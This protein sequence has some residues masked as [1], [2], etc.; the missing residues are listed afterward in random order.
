MRV[1]GAM[2]ER[3]YPFVVLALFVALFVWALSSDDNRQ[4]TLELHGMDNLEIKNVIVEGPSLTTTGFYITSQIKEEF[5]GFKINV[6]SPVNEGTATITINSENSPPLVLSNMP[7]KNGKT[8]YIS[9][10]GGK[11]NY[12]KAHW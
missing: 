11:L 12:V 4:F 8:N 1:L 3:L 6:G 5:E 10:N 2:K 9:L 7:Y